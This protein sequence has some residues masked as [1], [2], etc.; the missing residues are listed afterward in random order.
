MDALVNSAETELDPKKRKALFEQ[1]L[2]K[3]SEDVPEIYVGF[4]PR[5]F[6]VRDRVKGFTTDAAGRFMPWNGGLT[7]TW[8][9]K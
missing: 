7:H 9:D 6:T 1:I 3:M 2:T 4:V 8:L 5:F